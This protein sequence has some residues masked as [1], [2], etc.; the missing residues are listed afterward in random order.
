[1][2]GL[3]RPVFDFSGKSVLV[4]GGTSGMGAAA[5][6]AFARSGARVVFTGRSQERAEALLELIRSFG[7]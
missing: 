3:N 5:A 7:A 4:T 2:I 6:E 1:M